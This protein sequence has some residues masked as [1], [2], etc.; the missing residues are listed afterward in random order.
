[1]SDANFLYST[2]WPVTMDDP[3]YSYLIPNT[4]LGHEKLGQPTNPGIFPLV[5]QG[6]ADPWLMANMEC[7]SAMASKSM[8]GSSQ[9]PQSWHEQSFGKIPEGHGNVGMR[10]VS[11]IFKQD[12]V[13]FGD[14]DA[15]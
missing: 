3:E 1:M 4:A 5:F 7:N 13:Q 6:E 11:P 14:T 10:Y 8:N 15:P 2:S 9:D 12:P